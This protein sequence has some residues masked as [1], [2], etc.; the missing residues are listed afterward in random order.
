VGAGAA[1][2]AGGADADRVGCLL[3]R[4]AQLEAERNALLLACKQV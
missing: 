4:A 1:G 3:A 2:G